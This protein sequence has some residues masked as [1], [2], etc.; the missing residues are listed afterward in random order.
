MEKKKNHQASDVTWAIAMSHADVC[1]CSAECLVY[2]DADSGVLSLSCC[3][4]RYAHQYF[5]RVIASICML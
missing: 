2:T 5:H 3:R 4:S 1:L